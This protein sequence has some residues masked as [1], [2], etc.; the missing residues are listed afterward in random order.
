M[1]LWEN[2]CTWFPW[3]YPFIFFFLWCI[4][5]YV[6]F[7]VFK[8]TYSSYNARHILL[9][10]YSI[11]L[12]YICIKSV[13]Y[14]NLKKKGWIL[15]KIKLKYLILNFAQYTYYKCHFIMANKS[16]PPEITWLKQWR[17]HF[18]TCQATLRLLTSTSIIPHS[19]LLLN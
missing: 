12:I 1:L 14:F 8:V 2:K 11:M 3:I 13:N 10:P 9:W 19:I 15:I 6:G 16:K 5:F 4:H 17:F 7:H 18:H